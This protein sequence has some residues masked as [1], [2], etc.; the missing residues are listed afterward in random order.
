MASDKE[1]TEPRYYGIYQ[2][3]VVRNDDPEGVARLILRVPGVV[4]ESAWAFPFGLPGA[5]S[6]QRGMVDVPPQGSDVAVMFVAGDPERPMW[7]GGNF[8]KPAGATEV[9]SPFVPVKPADAGAVKAYE[10]KRWL[11]TYDERPGQEYFRIEDKV[12]G[13]KIEL[14]GNARG[15]TLQATSFL[16]IICKGTISLQGLNIQIGGRQVIRNGKPV[17]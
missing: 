16:N 12:S 6:P 17:Q 13:D 15:M 7:T 3:V 5:G 9:P 2:G 11:V 14:D 4:Q 1:Q 8:G 10:T